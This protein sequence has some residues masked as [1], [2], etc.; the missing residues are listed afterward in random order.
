VHSQVH[1]ITI[2]EIAEAERLN[3]DAFFQ[4]QDFADHDGDHAE[5][6]THVY[7]FLL[8]R[9]PLKFR[10]KPLSSHTTS[11]LPGSRNS[12]RR[13][14]ARFK[15]DAVNLSAQIS[16]SS[17]SLFV[18]AFRHVALRS[19]ET[20]LRVLGAKPVHGHGDDDDTS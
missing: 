19:S 13:A 12:R 14:R 2:P 15:T 5:Y 1:L 9:A 20:A 18:A 3:I 4:G 17:P 16:S 6:I 10:H 8:V 11:S 7:N